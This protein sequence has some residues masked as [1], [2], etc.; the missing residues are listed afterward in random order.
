[1]NPYLSVW[2]PNIILFAI[3][4]FVVRKVHKEIPFNSFNKIID[5]FLDGYDFILGII[6]KLPDK[7][8]SITK[9]NPASTKS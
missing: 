1:L 9:R 6:N 7:N 5:V 3:A 2:I 4:Y 8:T